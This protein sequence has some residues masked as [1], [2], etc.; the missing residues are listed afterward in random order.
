M[1][2][3]RTKA[4]SPTTNNT[5]DGLMRLEA[6]DGTVHYYRGEQGGTNNQGKFNDFLYRAYASFGCDKLEYIIPLKL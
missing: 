6:T 4:K 3:N 5:N 1:A 2:F